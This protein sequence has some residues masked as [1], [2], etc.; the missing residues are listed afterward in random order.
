MTIN[1]IIK[2]LRS[3]IKKVGKEAVSNMYLT[4]IWKDSQGFVYF[5]HIYIDV[6]VLHI[7]YGI[8]QVSLIDETEEDLP[9]F[10][11]VQNN[12]DTIFDMF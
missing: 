7:D 11:D 9:I 6:Y 10:I 4:R 3:Q 2:K 8:N 1:D 12:I 5:K